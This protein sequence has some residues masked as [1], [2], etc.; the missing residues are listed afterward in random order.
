MIAILVIH[1]NLTNIRGSRSD[2]ADKGGNNLAW[3]TQK[4]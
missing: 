4:Q 1:K 3:E 2:N